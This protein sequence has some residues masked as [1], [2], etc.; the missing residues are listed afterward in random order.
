MTLRV[1]GSVLLM[2]LLLTLLSQSVA[3]QPQ[4][5]I[6][7]AGEPVWQVLA[8]YQAQ[9][10]EILYSTGLVSAR[11]KFPNSTPAGTTLAHL[12]Q[13]LLS[14]GLG[15]KDDADGLRIIRAPARDTAPTTA[16]HPRV[17]AAALPS[18]EELVVVSSRYAVK[19]DQLHKRTVD[20]ELVEAVPRLGEDPIRIASYF[21]GMAGNGTSA[22]PYIR[23]GAQDELLVMF[24]NLELLEPFH[25]RDFQSVFSSFNPSVID[26]IDVYTG[27]FPVRYGDRMSGVMDINPTSDFGEGRGEVSLSLLNTTAMLY[28]QQASG[29]GE[30]LLSARRGNLDIVTKEINSTVGEPS[31]NDAVMQYRYALSPETELDIG[32]IYYSDDIEFRDFDEDGEIASSRYRNL[33]AWAQLH[34]AINPQLHSATVLYWGR[35]SHRRTGLL[36]DLELDNGE[37]MLDDDRSFSVMSLAQTFEYV[38]N[39]QWYFELGGRLNYQRG[40]YDYRASI[41]RG[42]FADLLDNTLEQ[43]RLVRFKPSGVSGG[44]YAMLRYKPGA[45]LSLEGGLRW[46][47]QDYPSTTE[48]QVSPRLSVRWHFN[49]RTDLFLSLG[50]FHQPEGIHELQIGDGIEEF[51]QVQYADHYIAGLQH[52]FGGSGW[53]IRTETFYKLFRDPKRR[54]ENLFNPLVLLPELAADRVEVAPSRGRAHGYELSL[55]YQGERSHAWFSY[56]HV[57]VEDRIQGRWEPRIWDQG[58]SLSAGFSY[59]HGGWGIGVAA[60]WHEGWRT[61]HIPTYLAEDEML[62]LQRNDRRLKDYFS[63][64][65]QISRTW[66]RGHHKITAFLELTNA[67]N[68]HNV[69]GIEYDVEEDEDIGGFNLT[70]QDETLLP[71]VPSLGVRWQ[72]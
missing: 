32:A 3:A 15:L 9:G 16:K 5:D 14:V 69:G 19:D 23:G 2:S 56:S 50:R 48:Q 49:A 60:V 51:Q 22:K 10:Y 66:Q 30:W 44:V 57:E 31:Y 1:A 27:G 18:I 36:L 72:F 40:S 47:V 38:A 25:L 42:V 12:E 61:T 21:P 20:L 45:S 11:L 65:L 26:H 8:E 35:I 34:T 17:V 4:Q 41:R 43:D 71:L 46:D 53:S 58:H 52:A 6:A 70:P 68:R 62:N 39:E 7:F 55:S 13:A 37:G 59:Q 33:Y 64:D 67:F 28:G 63:L 24:N 54:F 29:K